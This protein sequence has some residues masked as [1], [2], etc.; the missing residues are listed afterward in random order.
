[1]RLGLDQPLLN[2][3][4]GITVTNNV[5]VNEQGT[6]VM[7]TS[8]RGPVTTNS[9]VGS[10]SFPGFANN[11]TLNPLFFHVAGEDFGMGNAIAAALVAGAPLTPPRRG[12]D[13]RPAVAS[14]VVQRHEV[15]ITGMGRF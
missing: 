12:D 7:A 3:A 5:L 15:V 6:T 10:T 14:P 8:T 4:Y 13:T 1:L 9:P 11:L 2:N